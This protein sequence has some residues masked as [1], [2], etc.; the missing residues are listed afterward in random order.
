[1]RNRPEIDPKDVLLGP[2][3]SKVDSDNAEHSAWGGHEDGGLLRPALPC[4]S[5]G[6]CGHQGTAGQGFQGRAWEGSTS[7][8]LNERHEIRI[9]CT[10]PPL[11]M[12]A[13]DLQAAVCRWY[14][15][16]SGAPL[17]GLVLLRSILDSLKWM[18]SRVT[19]FVPPNEG[20]ISSE[21]SLP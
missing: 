21:M 7:P 1:M 11:R 13:H 12:D 3:E 9:P 4:A 6:E 10:N 19:S 17:S 2:G 14:G 8:S 15:S 5:L 16:L 20:G 18:L